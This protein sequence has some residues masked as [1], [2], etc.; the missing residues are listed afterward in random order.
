MQRAFY[1]PVLYARMY[2]TERLGS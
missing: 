1:P 2:T